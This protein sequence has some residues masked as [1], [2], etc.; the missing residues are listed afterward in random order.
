MASTAS[1]FSFLSTTDGRPMDVGTLTTTPR[2]VDKYLDTS[3]SDE[4][5]ELEAPSSAPPDEQA[6]LEQCMRVV[7]SAKAKRKPK[8]RKVATTT[9]LRQYQKEFIEA[10]TTEHQSWID[11]DVF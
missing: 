1:S 9:D 4:E 3:N 8:S 10:K 6:D 5:N 2:I 11:N 7:K